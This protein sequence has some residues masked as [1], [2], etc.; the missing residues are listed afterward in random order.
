VLLPLCSVAAQLSPA[1]SYYDQIATSSQVLINASSMNDAVVKAAKAAPNTRIVIPSGVYSNV[2]LSI[3]GSGQATKPILIEGQP[4][5]S[6]I[7]TGRVNLTVSGSYVLLRN[8]Y[9]L[10]PDSNSY[11]SSA[12]NIYFDNCAY[13]GLYNSHFYGSVAPVMD[14]SG[15]DAKGFK[16]IIIAPT[17]QSVEIGHNTFEGKQ[18]QDSVVLINRSTSR[19]QLFEGHRIFSN[20]FTNRIL[21]GNNAN[22]FDVIRI[23]DSSTS[24]SP[25]P[26]I[27]AAAVTGSS[28]Q[29]VGNTVEFNVFENGS[30]PTALYNSCLASDNWSSDACKTEPEIISVKAPQSIIRFNTFRNNTGGLT[31]RHG[32][33][34]IVEG[35]YITGENIP[36]GV[37]MPMK[38]S[39]GM[40]VIGDHHLIVNNHF[41]NT[42]SSSSIKAG[43]SVLP[44]VPNSPINGYWQVYDA[45]I[46]MNFVSNVQAKPV[47]FASDYGGSSKT[48]LPQDVVFSYN[49]I[50]GGSQAMFNQAPNSTYLGT[51]SFNQNFYDEQALGISVSATKVSAVAMSPPGSNGFSQPTSSAYV[52][53][54]GLLATSASRISGLLSELTQ[55][56]TAQDAAVLQGL[57]GFLL[58]KTGTLYSNFQPLMRNEVGCSFRDPAAPRL[59]DFNGDKKADLHWTNSV[60][61]E[62]VIWQMNGASIESFRGTTTV[63]DSSWQVAAEADFDNDGK[64]DLLW[65]NNVTG[66]NYMWLNNGQSFD[67]L[68]VCGVSDLNWH[69]VGTADFDGDGKVDIFWRNLQTGENY[70]WFM[71]GPTLRYGAGVQSV[72]G[73][74]WQIVAIADFNGDGKP[75]ILWRNVTTGYLYVWLMDGT[76][77][78]SSGSPGN[79]AD[80]NWQ[81]AAVADFDGDGK[82]EILWRHMVSGA[83]YMWILNGTSLTN[84]VGVQGV[85]DLN[86]RLAGTGDM[87]GDGKADLIW[88]NTSTGFNY[89]WF[90][91]G[92]NMVN[93][94]PIQP[95]ADLNWKVQ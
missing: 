43:I 77:L 55:I 11:G 30:L 19:A 46:A 83:N 91:N 81:I 51:F 32:F 89:V 18:N 64:T 12:A 72:T 2:D 73:Q 80:L 5:G 66:A 28:P 33:Q 4:D 8:L 15:N 25:S 38:E 76:T 95:V 93:S 52:G 45:V 23:G 53:S 1:A 85:A 13:C 56:S 47:S 70:I 94:G 9:V 22:D 26:S 27:A 88:R 41:E 86:W 21:Q 40:R 20:L 63:N 60:T 54:D 10:N 35:N 84:G 7:L 90:M 58:M 31:L 87:D 49:L 69:I 78:V 62:G 61:G 3:Q 75:D 92:P 29:I 48:V 14:G 39:Y 74:D 6:T 37:V 59:G 16:N 67:G 79:V 50:S 44:G 57:S 24:Q 65:R 34:D 68:Y 71:D 36:Q 42:D 82:A 17:S